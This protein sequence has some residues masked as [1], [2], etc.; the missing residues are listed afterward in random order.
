MDHTLE[1]LVKTPEY[2]RLIAAR[3]RLTWPLLF[4]T[5]GSYMAFILVIA[6]SPAAL[7]VSFGG[8]VISWGIVLGLALILLMFFITYYYARQTNQHIEPLIQQ[9]QKLAGSK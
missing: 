3:H 1:A 8:G 4:I 9:M 6:F 7:G 2:Q 5:F